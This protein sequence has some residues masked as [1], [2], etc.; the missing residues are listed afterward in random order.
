MIFLAVVFVY[1][2]HKK[3]NL[4]T[5]IYHWL[6]LIAGA[7]IVMVSYMEDYV[8][9]MLQKFSLGDLLGKADQGQLL[10][11][12]SNYVPDHFKWWLFSIGA[13]LHILIIFHILIINRR[14]RTMG[15]DQLLRND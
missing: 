14:N 15:Y 5:K 1:F 3:Q 6:F 12:A 4:I 10:D 8:S 2:S 7:I 13:G 9:Y 11:F